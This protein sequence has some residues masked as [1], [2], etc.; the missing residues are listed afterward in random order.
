LNEPRGPAYSPGQAVRD[1]RAGAGQRVRPAVPVAGEVG[2]TASSWGFP[3]RDPRAGDAAGRSRRV[4]RPTAP[5]PFGDVLRQARL[6]R[7]LSLDDVVAATRIPRQYL[8]AFEAEDY[9]AL[10]APVYARGLV[11]AYAAYLELAP[12]LALAGFRPPRQAVIRPAVP[13]A[14]R[15]RPRL[16]PWLLTLPLVAA[17]LVLLGQYLGGQYGALRASLDRPEAAVTPAPLDLP[18]PLVRAWT[19]LPREVPTPLLIAALT[20]ADTPTPTPTAGPSPT[21]EPVALTAAALLGESGTPTPTPTRT[22]TPTATPTATPRPNA[23]V[24]VEARV[25][26]PTWLQVW[27]DGRQVFAETLPADTTRTFTANDRLRMRAGNSGG[28][29]VTINGEPQGRLGASGQAVDVTWGRR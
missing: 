29:Q 23:P 4:G 20:A 18:E 21:L 5:P 27:A 26:E 28:V 17:A 25:V 12:E 19:P 15:A 1:G 10:P 13:P 3:E 9:A 2:A 24:V 11:R 16:S 7:G 8:T 22:P 6:A 14:P